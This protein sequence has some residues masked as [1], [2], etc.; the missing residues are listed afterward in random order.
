MSFNIALSGLNSAAADLD[1]TS[2]NIANTGTVGFKESRAEFADIFAAS[3]LGLAQNA[4]GQGSRLTNVRQQFGQGN[5][6]F[7]GNSLDL[8]INQ[9]GF[10]RLNDGGDISY[11]RNGAFEL[12]NEGYIVSADGKNLTGYTA[13]ADGELTGAVGDLQVSTG[14]LDPSPST[15]MNLTANLDANEEEPGTPFQDDEPGSYND[16]TSTTVYDSL[17]RGHLATLY[18][19]KGP[20]DNEWVIHTDVNGTP[21]GSIDVTFNTDGTLATVNGGAGTTADFAVD[22]A[23]TDGMDG[24]DDLEVSLDLAS[25]TQFGT[26]FNVA[27]LRQN[28]YTAG[29][30]SSL[31]VGGDGTVFGRFSN[32]QSRVLGQ[33]ALAQFANPEKLTQL[34]ETSW[35]ES[36]ESGA[37]LLGA[38]GTSGLGNIESGALEESNVNITEQLVKMI[39]AQRN[40][41]ANAKMISTQD[42]VTQEI[43]NIR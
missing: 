3:Q 13:N 19:V 34:G 18:F 23:D 29:Q 4:V 43:I 22:A 39:T 12:N 15:N 28:G 33:V 6:D 20:A 14:D 7:T 27:E 1:V 21:G 41:Q 32:G 16:S 37:P 11:S 10:F 30:F 42:Q 26:P 40:F 31:D 36:F 8:A 17:G 24:A 25:L 9:G 2:N 38:P 5:F 35:A